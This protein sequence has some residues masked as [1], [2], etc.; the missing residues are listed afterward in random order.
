MESLEDEPGELIT[1]EMAEHVKYF[2]CISLQHSEHC[3]CSE[4]TNG[5]KLK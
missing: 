5:T 2:F 3:K 4:D 1:K